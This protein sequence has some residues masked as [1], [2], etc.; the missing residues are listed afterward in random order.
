MLQIFIYLFFL[1]LPGAEIAY[2]SHIDDH[3]Y[4]PTPQELEDQS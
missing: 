3:L 2:H 4:A 1:Q